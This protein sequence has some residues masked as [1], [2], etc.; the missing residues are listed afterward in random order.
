MSIIGIEIPGSPLK[1]TID[2]EAMR[3]RLN[4]MR[5]R[6]AEEIQLN[7]GNATM[8]DRLAKIDSQIERL[9]RLSGQVVSVSAE[10]MQREIAS[11]MKYLSEGLDYL[12]RHERGTGPEAGHL[13]RWFDHL[14]SVY[15]TIDR[16]A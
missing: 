9:D 7:G 11:G 8:V 3:N 12:Q 13:Q 14:D 16:R 2:V 5:D 15:R 4:T 6:L 10:R 1:G